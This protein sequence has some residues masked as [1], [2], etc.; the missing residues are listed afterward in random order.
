MPN[1][2]F[3]AGTAVSIGVIHTLVGPDHYVPFVAMAQ[4]RR[5]S[6][7]RLALITALCGLGHIGSSVLLGALGIALGLAVGRLDGAESARG[8]IAAWALTGF[9]L[10]YMAWGLRQAY[11]GRSHK[12]V[13]SHGAGVSHEHD[14]EHRGE[15]THAH[16]ERKENLTPWILFTIFV[17]GPCEPLIPILMYP[18]A[19]SSAWAVAWVAAAFGLATIVTM[20]AAVFALRLGVSRLPV[21]SLERYNHALAGAAILACAL[22]IHIGL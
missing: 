15:H 18:A 2:I 8:A 4:A 14:H 11:R 10:A 19:T 1:I 7:S 20:L 13:H 3:L 6:G 17:L 12:H 22:A 16:E 21:K 5:W 9:G